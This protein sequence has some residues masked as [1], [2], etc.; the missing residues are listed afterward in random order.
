MND[1]LHLRRQIIKSPMERVADNLCTV[2]LVIASVYFVG[3]VC[4]TAWLGRF[5]QHC[6]EVAR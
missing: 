2:L 6:I 1:H 5:S 4:W 3:E